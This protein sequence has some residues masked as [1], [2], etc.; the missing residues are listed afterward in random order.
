MEFKDFLISEQKEYFAD[1]VNDILTGVHELLQAKKQ[2]G[3]RQLIRNAESIA[4]QIR[5]V[6]HTSW[7]R[8]EHKHLKTLQKCGVA[9]M[10]TIEDKGDLSDTFNSVRV[11]L[12]NLSRKLGVPTNQL[13][14]GGKEEAPQRPEPPPPGSNGLQMP[15]QGQAPQMPPPQDLMPNQIQS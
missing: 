12:E 3:A 15:Q 10:K 7:P 5:K 14:T 2:M 13:G 8:S 6:L 11:E 1:R 4:N 9:L